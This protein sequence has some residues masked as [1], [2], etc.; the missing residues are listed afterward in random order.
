MTVFDSHF[1]LPSM[2]Q[3]GMDI[4]LPSSFTGLECATLPDDAAERIRLVGERRT[5]FM[6]MG[7]GPWCTSS[8]YPLSVDDTIKTLEEEISLYGADAVGECGFDFH[9]TYGSAGKQEK[10]FTAQAEIAKSL[11]VPLIIHSRDADEMLSK[12]LSLI[13]GRTIMHCFSSGREM[14][15][16]LLE[17]GAYIS[18]AGNVTYKNSRS[19]QEA[20]SSCPI[21]R[22]LYETDSPYLTPVPKRG[23]MNKPENTEY[24]LR[25]LSS[26]RGEDPEYIKDNVMKNFFSLMKNGESVVRRETAADHP[27]PVVMY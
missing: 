18:F 15:E 11:S 25:F 19:L 9:W 6:S 1:H 5:V 24:T 7:A 20:A 17:R 8:T 13:D 12:H 27:V 4:S 10:L 3:R 23:E 22:M 26:L 21:E 16:K 14:M 2:L